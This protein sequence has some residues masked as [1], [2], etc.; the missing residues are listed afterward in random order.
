MKKQLV[1]AVI[2]GA[3]VFAGLNWTG[4]ES[5]NAVQGRVDRLAAVVI[6]LVG[7]NDNLIGNIEDLERELEYKY[8]KLETEQ[9]NS[10]NL[11]LEIQRLEQQ[12]QLANQAAENL[13]TNTRNQ[14][15]NAMQVY[16]NRQV[17]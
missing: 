3:V 11:L 13:D 7:E 14:Y 2:G 16:E 12:L 8:D 15:N 9:G 1:G 10:N 4:Q 5:L 6:N 17:R